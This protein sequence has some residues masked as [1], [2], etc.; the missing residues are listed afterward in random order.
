MKNTKK[1]RKRDNEK[2]ERKGERKIQRKR[3]GKTERDG[4]IQKKMTNDG[5]EEERK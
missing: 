3:E 4:K 5:K 1:T 2:L